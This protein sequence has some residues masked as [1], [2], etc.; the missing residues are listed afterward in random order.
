[1]YISP[2]FDEDDDTD[3]NFD[4]DN[5]NDDDF[6]KRKMPLPDLKVFLSVVT[7]QDDC[8]FLQMFCGVCN[9]DDDT[10]DSDKD[11]DFI[12]GKMPQKGVSQYCHQSG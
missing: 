10:D 8:I 6:I 3:D 12:K 7:N 2:D 11:D 4:N 9:E 5:Y 1:M